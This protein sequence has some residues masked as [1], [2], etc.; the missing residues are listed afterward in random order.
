MWSVTNEVCDLAGRI[1]EAYQQV[2]DDLEKA[3]KPWYA[4]AARDV[5]FQVDQLL[6]PRFLVEIPYEWLTQY[7]RYFQAIIVRLRKLANAGLERDQRG[8][9]EIGQHWLRYQQRLAKHRQRGAL[10]PE[11]ERYRWM[12]EELRVA[13]FAHELRTAMPVSSKRLELQ[14]ERVKA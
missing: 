8:I 12:I 4:A 1:A 10:D 9:E 2:E 13:L 11:L 5:E 6:L 7:P 14:W 3:S